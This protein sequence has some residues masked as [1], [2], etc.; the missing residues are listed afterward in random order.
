MH[1]QLTCVMP[2]A[3]SGLPAVARCSVEEARLLGSAAVAA[4]T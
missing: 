4:F 3:E 2:S 1:D